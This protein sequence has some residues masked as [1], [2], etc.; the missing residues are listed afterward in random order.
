MNSGFEIADWRLAGTTSRRPVMG[1]EVGVRAGAVVVRPESDTPLLRLGCERLHKLA[2][3]VEDDLEVLVVR[4]E[5]GFQLR[6]FER[7]TTLVRSGPA[8]PHEGPDHKDADF[9]GPW[10][11]EHACCHDCTVFCE[12]KRPILDVAAAFEVTV[13]DLKVSTSSQVSWN[14]KSGGKRLALRLTC[15]F[16]RLAVTPYRAARSWLSITLR[17]RISMI[18]LSIRSTGIS[19]P[20]VSPPRLQRYRASSVLQHD[21]VC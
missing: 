17:P 4:G 2:Q 5:L 13:C 3:G 19:I 15:S 18:A 20:A 8:Q 6:Q 21:V 14:M 11:V 1:N 12:R 9:D 7:Q 10:G 16:R